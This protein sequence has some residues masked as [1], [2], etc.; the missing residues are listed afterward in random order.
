[1]EIKYGVRPEMVAAGKIV[2]ARR[3]DISCKV[4]TA[5][6]KIDKLVEEEEIENC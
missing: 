4:K 3:A 1:M 2:I 6:V 5:N